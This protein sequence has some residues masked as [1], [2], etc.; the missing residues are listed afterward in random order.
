MTLLK[1]A[2][3]A[4]AVAM[5]ATGCVTTVSG[6]GRPATGAGGIVGVGRDIARL[7]PD[8]GDFMSALGTNVSD[9]GF[10]PSVGTLDTLPDGIRTDQDASEIEC[11]GVTSPF[12][13][14][15]YE[16]SSVQAVATQRW[17]NWDQGL[18][19]SYS[20]DTG[21][22]AVKNPADA[23][24]LFESFADQWRKCEGKTLILYHAGGG[25]DQYMRI[26][27]VRVTDNTVSAIVMT[28]SPATHTPESPDERALGVSMNCIVDV[29]VS[30]SSWRTG[31]P[32]PRNMAVPIA[33]A[34]LNKVPTA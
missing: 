7:L 29:S 30:D 19:G 2:A 15:V 8:G 31:N 24:A 21:A 20:V 26:T 23:R 5:L 6:T 3:G 33:E 4:L 9:S 16:S 28:S 18:S 1:A 14:K 10:P 34:M 11:L 12:M 27:N 13:K 22:I 32:M 17:D 25:S